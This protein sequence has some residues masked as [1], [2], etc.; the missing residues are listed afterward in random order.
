MKLEIFRLGLWNR[1]ENSH[2]LNSDDEKSVEGSHVSMLLRHSN[3][4]FLG[5]FNLQ[6]N[7]QKLNNL[8]LWY[9]NSKISFFYLLPTQPL[10]IL[11]KHLQI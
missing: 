7:M 2:E 5:V 1:N 10:Q 4:L 8:N 3:E 9:E 11:Q 6:M